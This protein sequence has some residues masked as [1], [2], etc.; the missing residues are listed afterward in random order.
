MYGIQGVQKIFSEVPDTYELVNH[1]LTCGLDMWWRT[2]AAR[3]A[4]KGGTRWLDV[5]SGTGGMAR[6]LEAFAQEK[7][8][9][10][11]LDFCLP[12][13]S[14]AARK[15]AKSNI[16]FCL[17]D[18]KTLPFSENTFDLVTISFATRNINVNKVILIQYFREFHRVLKPGGMF[19]NL[20]TSQ[21]PSHFLRTVLHLYARFI[22]KPIGYALSGSKAAYR[23][24]SSTIPR[25]F[26]GDEL[27][28][29]ISQAGFSKVNLSYMT[30]GI[31]AIHTAKK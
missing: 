19:V 17:S 10:T 6:S 5:C 25:F 22:I 29:I 4:A 9:I 26:C 23:Y 21:P 2:Q 12:M 3:I 15:S 18:A 31:A 28:H 11:A 8:M 1:V 7:T 24:L 20:E 27:S 14:K 30:F 13:L 16:S